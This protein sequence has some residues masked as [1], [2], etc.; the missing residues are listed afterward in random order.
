MK[1]GEAACD[2]ATSYCSTPSPV[3]NWPISLVP[4]DRPSPATAWKS[5]V[6]DASTGRFASSTVDPNR[7]TDDI[8]AG[9]MT[10]AGEAP[11][12]Q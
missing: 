10:E 9:D 11:S 1:V 2:R 4:T 12:F 7:V 3:V 5:Y 6:V 8:D